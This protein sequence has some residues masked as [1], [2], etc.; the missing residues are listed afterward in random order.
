MIYIIIFVSKILENALGTLRLIVVSHG[1]KI[2]GSILQ[3]MISIVW[4]IIT[5]IV[6]IDI[7][8][9]YFKAIAFILGSGV[10]SYLG[11]LIESKLAFGN[12]LLTCITNNK[13]ELLKK[14]TNFKLIDTSDKDKIMILIS[15]KKRSEAIKII[16]EVDK[17]SLIIIEKILF[18]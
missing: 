7:K 5:S 2:L 17:D 16:K 15:R 14:L 1:K 13:K 11:S 3:I 12:N 18:N 4:L 9:D 8:K 10:G 6:I